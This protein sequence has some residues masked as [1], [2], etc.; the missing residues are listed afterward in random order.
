MKI[1]HRTALA[2]I[3]LATA[4]LLAGCSGTGSEPMPSTNSTTSAPAASHNEQDTTFAQMMI[5]HHKGAI[6]MAGLAGTRA[7]APQVKE[8]A[9]HIKAAQ[10]PEIQKMTSWLKTWG[11]PV[12]MPG[13]DSSSP[14]PTSGDMSGMDMSTPMPTSSDSSGMDSSM[15]GMTVQD[16]ASLRAA[17]GPAFDKQFLTLMIEHH[18]GAV[19]MA[20]DELS[21]GKN[22]AAKELAQSIIT[23]QSKEVTEMES[24]LSALA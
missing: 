12:T 24:M 10:Q 22:A 15:P 21:T 2:G 23:S 19:T 20:K 11:E 4:G 17:T 5:V 9:T 8:L 13:M 7:S 16:M 18:E 1:S 3:A 6:E 14:A